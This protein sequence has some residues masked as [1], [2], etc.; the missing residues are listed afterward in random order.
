MAFGGSIGA[1]IRLKKVPG[2]RRFH[3][4]DFLL[5]SESNTRFICEVGQAHRRRF[6]TKMRGLPCAR[7]GKTIADRELLI[8]GLD[9]TQVVRLNLAEAEVAWRRALTKYF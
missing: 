1:D 7:V 2:A 9:G 3:R 6:E 5:F 8:A 4:D